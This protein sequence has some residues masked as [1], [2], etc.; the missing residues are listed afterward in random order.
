MLTQEYRYT[1]T[2]LHPETIIDPKKQEKI[3]RELMASFRE[4]ASHKPKKT[5]DT[6]KQELSEHKKRLQKL[7]EILQ[8]ELPKGSET[9][10]PELKK[11]EQNNNITIIQQSIKDALKKFAQER[12]NKTLF[13]KLRPLMKEVGIFVLPDVYFAFLEK[14]GHIFEA[15]S[16]LFHPTEIMTQRH[17][18]EEKVSQEVV[19]KE[20]SS[21]QGNKHIHTFL[22]K[23]YRPKTTDILK[24]S[25]KKYYIYT[26]LREK[27]PLFI[28]KKILKNLQK[29][30]SIA[31][32]VTIFVTCLAVFL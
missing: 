6:A 11:L 12:K 16:P 27:T 20:Y 10:I 26:L 4:N 8:E 3:F 15:I 14:I 24:P 2:K 23:K 18:I 17:A 32:I 30:V 7:L 28:S 13:N 22:R 25:I 1:L 29:I 5:V 9:L 31:L 21:I 19:E